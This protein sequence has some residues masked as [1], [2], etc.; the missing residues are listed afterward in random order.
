MPLVSVLLPTWNGAAELAELLPRLA[1]QRVPGGVEL[2]AIDSSS[3][4]QSV[5]LLCA[6]GARVEVIPAAE[7]GHGRTRNRLAELAR[8][9]FLA[10]LSQDVLPAD[11]GYLAALI[12]PFA[13]ARVAGVSARVLPGAGADPLAVRTVLDLPEASAEA[14]VWDLDSVG[15]IWDLAPAERA[16]CL[17]FNNVASAV[18]ADVFRGISFPNVAFGEDFAWAARALT[19]GYRLAYAPAALAFHAHAYGPRAAFRRYRIDAEFHAQIHGWRIRPSLASLARG[20][21]YELRRDAAWLARER[22]GGTFRALLRAPG[23]RAAQ[24]L[25]QY[26]GSRG[27]GPRVWRGST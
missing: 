2:V 12:A 24:V 13:D 1:E 4:D 21:L 23:L 15:P 19:A 20:L 16:R 10:F 11:A 3:Q 18:R 25:G 7:F 8:G 26:V 6:A 5:A 9:E 14:R 22:P 27:R 17:R